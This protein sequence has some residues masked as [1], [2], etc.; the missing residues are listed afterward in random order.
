MRLLAQLSFDKNIGIDLSNDKEFVDSLELII[1]DCL[2]NTQEA[3]SEAPEIVNLLK[4]CQQI[5]WNMNMSKDSSMEE[6]NKV[7]TKLSAKSEAK[8]SVTGEHVMIS[9][10]TASRP[11][12]L[13]IKEKLESFGLKVW[14]E[15]NDIHGS[16]L[17]SMSGAVE[18]SFC[19]LM[20]VTEKYRQSIYCQAEANYAFRRN[21]HIIP[22]IMQTGFEDVTGWLGIIMGTSIFGDVNFTKYDFDECIRRLKSEL[23][24]VLKRT[25][26]GDQVRVSDV[27]LELKKTAA[28]CQQEQALQTVLPAANIE[29]WNDTKVEEWFVEKNL[30][31]YILEKIRPCDGRILKQLLILKKEAPEFFYSSLVSEK[32]DL[33]TL[34]V[35]SMNLENLF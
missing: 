17:D 29:N 20:C 7:E 12:C 18:Q 10:N 8:S 4:T 2:K 13:R 19:V 23:D 14:I 31:P 35:F 26:T 6:K 3:S 5:K 25:N 1:K 21:K 15:V 28:A 24:N 30:S 11:L 16:S 34:L 32:I 22:C 9:Y 33:N 27:S